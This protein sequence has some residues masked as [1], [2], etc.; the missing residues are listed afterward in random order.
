M[1]AC[2]HVDARRQLAERRCS[3]TRRQVCRSWNE[4]AIGAFTGAV[5]FAMVLIIVLV[6]VLEIGS[7]PVAVGIPHYHSHGSPQLRRLTQQTSGSIVQISVFGDSSCSSDYR[8]RVP[9]FGLSTSASTIG[10][11]TTNIGDPKLFI[12]RREGLWP[13]PDQATVINFARGPRHGSPG[14]LRKAFYDIHFL[15]FPHRQA[16]STN[17]QSLQRL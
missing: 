16:R 1:W 8:V 3:V 14:S 7:V 17:D 10:W 9:P 4:R 2:F 6:L 15:A 13:L 11:R 12:R 5:L